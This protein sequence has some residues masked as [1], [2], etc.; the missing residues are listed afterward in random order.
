MNIG[1]IVSIIVVILFVLGGIIFLVYKI[2]SNK[3]L[4]Y[5]QKSQIKKLKENKNFYT[6]NKI[7]KFQD[8]NKNESGVVVASGYKSLF[9][10]NINNKFVIKNLNKKIKI[11]FQ[12]INK[13]KLCISKTQKLS[14]VCIAPPGSG[15]TQALLLPT[16]LYN[17]YCKDKP[18]LIITDPKPE[19]FEATKNDLISNGYKVINLSL[20]EIKENNKYK[21]DFWN[22]FDLIIFNLNKLLNS[23]NKFEEQEICNIISKE[24]N[25]LVES[26]FKNQKENSNSY[27]LENGIL[28]LKFFISLF[29]LKIENKEIED[30]Y[31]N[32]KN[33]AINI[34]SF[35]FNNLNFEIKE[36]EE[37]NKDTKT[38]NI[39]KQYT[40][41][42]FERDENIKSFIGFANKALSSFDSNYLNL[43]TSKTTFNLDELIL[44]N[45]PLA[46]FLTMN[47]SST[48]TESESI[49]LSVYLEM[50]NKKID[51]LKNKHKEIKDKVVWWFVDECGNIPKLNF[52]ET[53][54][55]FGRGYNNFALPVF[56]TI[57]QIK[58]KY[59]ETLLY[60]CENKILFNND[61]EKLADQISKLSG[62]SYISNSK[63]F[64]K[65]KMKNLESEY[66][67]NIPEGFLGL[68]TFKRKSKSKNFYWLP[69]TY[70]YMINNPRKIMKQYLEI[71]NEEY[72]ITDFIKKT[73]TINE[74]N[75]QCNKN[76]IDLK[77]NNLFDIELLG[78]IDS[79][80]LKLI[81]QK[82]NYLSQLLKTI[83]S[84]WTGLNNKNS[85]RQFIK[86][87]F[88]FQNLVNNEKILNE[89][90][91][92]KIVNSIENG[93]YPDLNKIF[94]GNYN[95]QQKKKN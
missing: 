4:N 87:F 93:K 2:K 58:N 11:N 75:E 67:N 48:T 79:N 5:D 50:L 33:L 65:Q 71:F 74:M 92:Y 41:F 54:I 43:L 62:D 34:N 72:L 8:W 95:E 69:I 94:R 89:S 91:L 70:F 68:W 45:K 44:N 49:L 56:Q 40:G 14:S 6:N 9:K 80:N 27:W 22:P 52:L 57:D 73:L 82:L 13:E 20:K 25:Y 32:F 26:F 35:S 16:I 28:F 84:D 85:K 53:I 42:S 61:N 63:N 37:L 55:T 29:L 90:N 23:S 83:L 46:I 60:G 59:S 51:I 64:T 15:K 86:T 24:I 39:L 38:I 7:I 18:I 47:T 77:T 3:N 88:E 21:T 76:K 17:I 31:L 66:I 10:Q 30:K 1:I 78:N 19:I 12:K 81:N 36:L